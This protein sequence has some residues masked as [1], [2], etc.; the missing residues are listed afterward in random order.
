MILVGTV[1]FGTLFGS[2]YLTVIQQADTEKKFPYR[3]KLYYSQIDGVREGTVVSVHGVAKGIVKELN[4]IPSEFVPD[5]RFLIDGRTKSIELTLRMSEPIT[6]WDNYEVKFKAQTPFSGRSINIDPGSSTNENSTFFNPN[7]TDE[8]HI[9]D[10]APSAAYYDD[11]FV[12]AN[13]ILLEN[14]ADLR[15]LTSNLRQITDKLNSGNGT[16]PQIINKDV[17]YNALGETVSDATI[18]GTELRRSQEGMREYSVIPIPFT[19]NLYK[20]Q[21]TIGNISSSVYLNQSPGN[22]TPAERFNALDA[23]SKVLILNSLR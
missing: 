6:L 3:L 2:F 13:H 15:I 4:I 18:F 8:H 16:I 11:F 10:F 23:P 12:A 19:I 20:R 21:T 1:F 17:L 22:N 5:K 7:Y 9:A 14:R